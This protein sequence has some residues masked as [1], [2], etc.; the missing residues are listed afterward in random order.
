MISLVFILAIF[1]YRRDDVIISVR[2]APKVC[3]DKEDVVNMLP[4]AK[5]NSLPY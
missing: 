4:T 5:Q 3:A 1:L 2:D